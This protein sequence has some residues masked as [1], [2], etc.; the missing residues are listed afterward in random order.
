MKSNHQLKED[1]CAEL[2]FDPSIDTKKVAVAVLDGIVTLS[3]SVS[4]FYEKWS[5]ERAVKRVAGVIGIAE[6]LT[7]QPYPIIEHS[8]TEIAQAARH[9]IKWSVA[10]AEEQI[11]IMVENGMITL[12]GE[13]DW[14][15]QK[16]NVYDAV[17]HLRGVQGV[18]NRI[19][20]K[21]YLTSADVRQKIEAALKRSADLDAKKVHVTVENGNVTLKGNLSTWTERDTASRVAWNAAGVITVNNQIVVSS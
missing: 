2:D 1:V 9:A 10:I 16:Q 20:L 15:Y 12:E 7:V 5:V 13:V 4:N 6:E 3:G 19:A 21:P 8:D 14:H 11:Q 18:H 17:I